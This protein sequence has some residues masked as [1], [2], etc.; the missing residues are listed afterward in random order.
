MTVE[1]LE[2]IELHGQNLGLVTMCVGGGQ[3]VATNCEQVGKE[4]V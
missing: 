3:G 1:L 2:E 4:A